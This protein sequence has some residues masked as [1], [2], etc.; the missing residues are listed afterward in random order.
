MTPNQA[1]WAH[2]A[3][4]FHMCWGQRM[5]DWG[6]GSIWQLWAREV[7]RMSQEAWLASWSDLWPVSSALLV[8]FKDLDWKWLIREPKLRWCGAVEPPDVRDIDHWM[9]NQ[10]EE[11][12]SCRIDEGGWYIADK[13]CCSVG[14]TD[15]ML[16]EKKGPRSRYRLLIKFGQWETLLWRPWR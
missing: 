4:P 11:P 13:I 2:S 3:M 6:G 12:W 15:Q 8:E 10:L 14:W 5:V 1:D 16:S 7:E 9:D